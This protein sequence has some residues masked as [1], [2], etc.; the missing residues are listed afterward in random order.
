MKKSLNETSVHVGVPPGTGAGPAVNNPS[1]DAWVLPAIRGVQARREY[2]VVLVKL[3][4]LPR[5]FAPIDAKMPPELRA[6][7]ALNKVRVPKIASDILGNPEDYT[8]SS[9]IGAI[10]GLPRFEPASEKSRLSTLYIPRDACRPSRRSAPARC[11]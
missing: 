5:F 9:L 10:D 11:D 6:Q 4:E 3:R 8:F 2:F 1:A 7:R